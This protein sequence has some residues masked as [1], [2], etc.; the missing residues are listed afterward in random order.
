MVGTVTNLELT[1]GLKLTATPSSSPF[2]YVGEQAQ[3]C[4]SL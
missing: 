2:C 4:Q 1:L 3:C